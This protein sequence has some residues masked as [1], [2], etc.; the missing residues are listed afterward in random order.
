[1]VGYYRR[2]IPNFSKIALPLHELVR[3]DVKWE[4]DERRDAA[5][6]ELKE[7]LNET[8]SLYLP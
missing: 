1:M 7:A 5:W 4:W 6:L 2:F 8:S 3:A